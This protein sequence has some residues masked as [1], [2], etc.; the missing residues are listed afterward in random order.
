MEQIFAIDFENTKFFLRPVLFEATD[1]PLR[2]NPVIW[3]HGGGDWFLEK[4]NGKMD[5]LDIWHTIII[6]VVEYSITIIIIPLL[7]K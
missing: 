5:D 7:W 4:T 6:I 1:R 2:L 3:P